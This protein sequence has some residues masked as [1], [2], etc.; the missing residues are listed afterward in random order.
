M[1]LAREVLGARREAALLHA[2]DPR[3]AVPGHNGGVLAVRPYADVRAVALG[4]HVEHRREIHVDAEPAKLT[5]LVHALMKRERLVP[6]CSEREVVGKDR[7]GP[8]QH[9]DPTALVIGGY[10]DPA[11]ERRLQLL[12]ELAVLLRRFEIAPVQ[13]QPSGAGVAE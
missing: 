2:L 8:A 1:A 10:E 5:R 3:D 7:R 4:E 6:R 12:Q 9:D 11:S 13:D